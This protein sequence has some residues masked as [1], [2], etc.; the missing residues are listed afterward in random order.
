MLGAGCRGMLRAAR[1][2]GAVIVRRRTAASASGTPAVSVTAGVLVIGTGRL[3]WPPIRR[4]V[5]LLPALGKTLE[6]VT[7]REVLS[8][9]IVDRALLSRGELPTR[10][11]PMLRSS[12]P[13]PGTQRIQ[14]VIRGIEAPLQLGI[15]EIHLAP[16]MTDQHQQELRQA[17][18]QADRRH[19]PAREREQPPDT[20]VVPAEDLAD[21]ARGD[22]R[23]Q[24]NRADDGQPARAAHSPRRYRARTH[25]IKMA[26]RH[27]CR[28]KS[29]RASKAPTDPSAS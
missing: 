22:A 4:G 11:R 2:G 25:D 21:K 14:P 20:D 8:R 23:N 12:L 16:R 24:Q 19:G 29:N 18:Q 7:D 6:R 13:P 27:H 1:A 17:A 9:E 3:P 26:R 28:N 5:F 15:A 10:G